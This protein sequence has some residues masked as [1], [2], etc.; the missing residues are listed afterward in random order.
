M[1][2]L[3]VFAAILSSLGAAQAQS[4]GDW[5]LARYRNGNYWFPGVI[6]RIAGERITIRYDDGDRETL[7]AD[8]VRPYD[9]RVGT[10]VE[11]NFRGAGR[12]YSGRIAALSGGTV[13]IDYDD[14]DREST[15]TG[16]CRSS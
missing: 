10:R 3:F 6:D 14:G 1:K 9:W 2:L 11:C 8:K 16:R 4:P 12:W 7:Y 13:R 15:N 5:V